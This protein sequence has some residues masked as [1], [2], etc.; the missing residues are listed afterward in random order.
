MSLRII[1]GAWKGKR[2]PS[3]PTSGTRPSADMWREAL[4]NALGHHVEFEGAEVWDLFAGTG[5]L[6]LECLSRGAAHC[7]FVEKD[8]TT[9]NALQNTLGS[10]DAT[11]R[12]RIV[13]S[14]VEKFLKANITEVEHPDNHV[15]NDFALDT[16]NENVRI[17][18][19]DPPYDLRLGNA[20]LSQ[21]SHCTSI[22]TLFVYEHGLT[23]ALLEREQWDCV[24]KKE[25]GNTVVEFFLH[26]R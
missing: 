3:P 8:K 21:L 7:T 15:H 1:A 2:I 17:V 18:L 6:G 22:G 13:H 20:L 4:F 23:E 25:R 5:S 11:S 10:F 19:A 9:C 12:T 24:W 16:L 14:S 26:V